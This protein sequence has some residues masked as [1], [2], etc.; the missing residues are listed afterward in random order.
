MPLSDRPSMSDWAMAHAT[1]HVC[2][3]FAL[4]LTAHSSLSLVSLTRSCCRQAE[5][6]VKAE[7]TLPS[8]SPDDAK[9]VRL[10]EMEAERGRQVCH[11][12]LLGWN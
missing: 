6:A 11:S 8:P 7:F 12:V 10:K 9:R 4:L 1:L 2:D 3:G 5:N